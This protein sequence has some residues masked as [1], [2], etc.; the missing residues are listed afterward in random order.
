V[1]DIAR[2]TTASG[3]K[4][5]G[6]ALFAGRW[7]EFTTPSRNARAARRTPV[8]ATNWVTRRYAASSPHVARSQPMIVR[9]SPQR[10]AA[11]PPT[12]VSRSLGSRPA[13]MTSVAVS[14]P[15]P[16]AVQVSAKSRTPSPT[17]EMVAA[18]SQ[19]R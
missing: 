17:F 7:N 8:T 10:S 2:G 3:K 12:S 11:V 18:P 1:S 13:V 5:L 4:S 16:E 19:A 9:R 6:K 15:K 14:A